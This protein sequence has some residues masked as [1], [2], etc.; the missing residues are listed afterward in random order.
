MLGP[1]DSGES[2]FT[3]LQK[4]FRRIRINPDQSLS[5]SLLGN[6]DD[7]INKSNWAD[8]LTIKEESFNQNNSGRNFLV[9]II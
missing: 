4:N 8:K 1:D 7:N 2:S 3:S 5:N 6:S 9:F